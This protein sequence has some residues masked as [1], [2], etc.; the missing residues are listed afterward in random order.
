MRD[1]WCSL[2]KQF[3]PLS[4]QSE[5]KLD[6]ASDVA[7]LPFQAIDIS[8][9]DRINALSE[10]NRNSM[11]RLLQGRTGRTNTGQN[12]VGIE[13]DQFFCIP[14]QTRHVAYA[15]TIIYLQIAPNGPARFLHSL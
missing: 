1:L 15:P 3:K 14:G 8:R 11:S 12:G 2:L 5:V 13:G 4:R 7:P 9:A 10:Y 6:K